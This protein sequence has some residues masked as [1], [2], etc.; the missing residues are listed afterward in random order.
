MECLR[1]MLTMLYLAIF[2]QPLLEAFLFYSIGR[3]AITAHLCPAVARS[4]WAQH[5]LGARADDAYLF[6]LAWAEST[7]IVV[8]PSTTVWRGRLTARRA[9]TQR[10]GRTI[11]ALNINSLPPAPRRPLSHSLFPHTFLGL[12]RR[13]RC[14][15]RSRLRLR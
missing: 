10:R 3:C 5:H 11:V 1:I 4:C 14:A 13:R 9:P 7:L 2:A 12:S 15:A 8:G 6:D